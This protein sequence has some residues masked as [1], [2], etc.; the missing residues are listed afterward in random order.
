MDE[1]GIWSDLAGGFIETDFHDEAG[2]AEAQEQI[3]DACKGFGGDLD[4]DEAVACSVIRICPDHEEQP[5]DGCE[6]CDADE[7]SDE[8]EG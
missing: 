8:D 3:D 2:K 4:P 1:Y 6:E 7:D 5:A